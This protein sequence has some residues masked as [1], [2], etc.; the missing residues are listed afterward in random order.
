LR[1]LKGDE[2]CTTAISVAELYRGTWISNNKEREES[3]VRKILTS[4]RVISFDDAC[5]G[6]Y[7][8]LYCK[9][10]SNMIND[11]DLMIVQQRTICLIILVIVLKI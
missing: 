11:A 3:K 2:L 4:I 5:A 6:I 9:L 1:S 8:E 10:R 7:A